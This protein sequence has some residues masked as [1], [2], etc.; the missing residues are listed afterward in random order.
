MMQQCGPKEDMERR[1]DQGQSKHELLSGYELDLAYLLSFWFT[2]GIAMVCLWTRSG[3]QER[4][5]KVPLLH[6][7]CGPHES[8][9]C[10]LDMGHSNFAI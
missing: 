8:V 7:V 5:T 1:P 2:C 10:G 9:G 6:A 4:T 3:K